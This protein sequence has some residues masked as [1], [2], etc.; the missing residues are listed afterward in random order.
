MTRCSHPV[1]ETLPLYV[2]GSLPPEEGAGVRAH[3]AGCEVCARETAA[4]TAIARAIEVHGIPSEPLGQIGQTR[5][6]WAF[7]FGC[8]LALAL[9][10]GAYESWSRRGLSFASSPRAPGRATLVLDLGTGVTRDT[11]ELPALVVPQG[12]ESVAFSL[13]PPV[14][15]DARYGLEL[16]APD[17]SVR[18]RLDGPLGLDRT[19]RCTR[20]FPA[21][22]LRPRGRYTIVVRESLPSGRDRS[23]EFP[24]DVR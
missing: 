19:G 16:R 1:R 13:F 17:G 11:S 9:A 5:R 20:A 4:L 2:N 15:A 6:P 7:A 14:D 8:V 10:I 3:L 21:S 24:F 12:A 22:L 23:Y 18:A